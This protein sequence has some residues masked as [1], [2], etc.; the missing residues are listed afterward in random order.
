MLGLTLL[1]G[2]VLSVSSVSGFSVAPY[3]ET[4]VPAFVMFLIFAIFEEYGWRGY[5]VPKLASTGI[6]PYLAY[7]IVGVVWATWHLPYIRELSWVYSAEDLAT[8][9]PRFYLAMLA[10]SILL[11]E[12]RLAT[13]SVWPAVLLHGL[14]NAVGHPL[15]AEYVTIAA[16]KEY[17]VSSTG[18]FMIILTGLLGIALNRWR[19]RRQVLVY[20]A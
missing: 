3:L 4:F 19:M 13:G 20:Q 8:F 10:N 17:L 14:A 1:I 12:I 2:G 15:F 6:N 5:L 7:V 16:G 9:I 18:L 11:N